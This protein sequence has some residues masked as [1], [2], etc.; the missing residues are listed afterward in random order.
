[1]SIQFISFR[2][3]V[4]QRQRFT[5]VVVVSFLRLAVDSLS[6]NEIFSHTYSSDS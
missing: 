2:K 3:T 4:V 6:S 5:C 1:M